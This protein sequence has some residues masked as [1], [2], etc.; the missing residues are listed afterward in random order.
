MSQTGRKFSFSALSLT[1][2]VKT[3]LQNRQSLSRSHVSIISQSVIATYTHLTDVHVNLDPHCYCIWV[4][5]KLILTLNQVFVLTL[6]SVFVKSPKCDAVMRYV[7]PQHE[8]T[9]V[10]NTHTH[11]H[12]H[13]CGHLTPCI[14]S[15]C[16]QKTEVI[17]IYFQIPYHFSCFMPRCPLR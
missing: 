6:Q 8:I 3:L 9:R 5:Q 7:C 4:H 17:S 16:R 10:T 11:A 2:S 14:I 1:L 13:R 12:L 15:G